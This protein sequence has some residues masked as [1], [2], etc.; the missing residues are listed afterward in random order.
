VYTL[1][2]TIPTQPPATSGGYWIAHHMADAQPKLDP[3]EPS[4]SPRM[5]GQTFAIAVHPFMRDTDL[6][7]FPPDMT[8]SLDCFHAS[9]R[10]YGRLV[11]AAPSHWLWSAAVCGTK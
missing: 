8:S 4:L 9:E 11:F 3:E 6:S 5:P 7:K 1:P 2:H 10:G